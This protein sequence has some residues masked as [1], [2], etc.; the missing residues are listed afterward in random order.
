MGLDV[1]RIRQLTGGYAL[2]SLPLATF[3]PHDVR[4]ASDGEELSIRDVYARRL[5]I[6]FEP[7]RGYKGH[8][9]YEPTSDAWPIEPGP[10]A[11]GVFTQQARA[12]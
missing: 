1:A 4:L 9:E 7:S 3:G 6:A 8:I 10:R 5:Y 2:E 12:E 11:N